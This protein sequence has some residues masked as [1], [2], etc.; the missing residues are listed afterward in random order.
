MIRSL[1]KRLPD[2]FDFQKEEIHLYQPLYEVNNELIQ[3]AQG[4]KKAETVIKNGTLV[5]VHTKE[6]QANQD[7]AIAY[8]RIAYIGNAT[9]T[10]GPETTV[11][12]ANGKY[13]SPGLMGIRLM[14]EEGRNLPLK[15]FTTF[16]S[17]VP[18]TEHLEDAG[19][20]LG[21]EAIKEGLTWDGVEGLG[22]VM[23]FPGVVNGDEK[24][25]G[26]INET[27]KA[28]KTVTGHFPDE[29]PKQ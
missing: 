21:V 27:L 26:E 15:V 22:E 11:I 2:S 1:E 10:I 25:I 13:L 19:A 9:H 5:N 29:D 3:V 20:R 12:D 8:G 23:N 7:I 4:K 18:A 24:M 17:C 16:P 14:H 28:G 6:L